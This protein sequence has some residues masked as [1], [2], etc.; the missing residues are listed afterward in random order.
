MVTVTLPLRI[1]SGLNMREH[2]RVRA[3]RV[4]QERTV[5]CLTLFNTPGVYRVGWP[6]V[7]TLTRVAPGLLDDDNLAGGFK[8][9]RDGVADA[10]GIDDADPRVTWRYQQRKG[11]RGE[12]KAIVT[13]EGAGDE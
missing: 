6:C 1:T 3:K 5:A 2:W 11:P 4:K 13:L 8:A 9:V 7:V 10:L 12:Y